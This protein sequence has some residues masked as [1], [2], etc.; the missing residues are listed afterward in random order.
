MEP[1]PN[2]RRPRGTSFAWG[3]SWN[4]PK[5][6][7]LVGI[8]PLFC[9]HSPFPHSACS[10]TMAESDKARVRKDPGPLSFIRNLYVLGYRRHEPAY[11]PLVC[12][13]GSVQRVDTKISRQKVTAL[14]C[15]TRH[16]EGRVRRRHSSLVRLRY[17]RNRSCATL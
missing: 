11:N 2:P 10:A 13:S 9:P 15:T 5:A 4:R 17:L 6:R 1:R 8:G 12:W 3:P 16:M 14:E 7:C